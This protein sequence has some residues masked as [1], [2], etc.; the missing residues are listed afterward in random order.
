MKHNKYKDEAPCLICS[1]C[2]FCVPCGDCEE[3]GC[4]RSDGNKEEL[5]M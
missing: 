1:R 2:F 4:G 3:Y 5:M